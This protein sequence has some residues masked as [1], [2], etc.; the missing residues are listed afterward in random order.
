MNFPKNHL[1]LKKLFLGVLLYAIY[2]KISAGFPSTKLYSLDHKIKI[3]SSNYQIAYFPYHIFYKDFLQINFYKKYH[4]ILVKN[5]K[6]HQS[7]SSQ[8]IDSKKPDSSSNHTHND[9][10]CHLNNQV[11]CAYKDSNTN[12]ST[13]LKNHHNIYSLSSPKVLLI[14]GDSL[15]YGY[16]VGIDNSFVSIAAEQIAK[17]DKFFKVVNSSI[18]GSTTHSGFSRLNQ[19]IIKDKPNYVLIALGANDGL[20]GSS[21]DDIYDNLEKMIVLAKKHDIKPMIAGMQIP[22]N[23]GKSYSESFK[24]VFFRLSKD[25]NIPMWDFM[26]KDVAGDKDKNLGDRIHP[27]ILGH[28]IIAKNFITWMIS[29]DII[30]TN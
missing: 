13:S 25:H 16:N 22:P 9:N 1:S 20:R 15:A 23:M 17:T 18:P 3:N 8:L 27:N 30:K 26:L 4:I 24:Q 14:I 7:I 10:N 12:K 6:N 2:A 11:T 21:V 5:Q 29:L 28:K 19:L